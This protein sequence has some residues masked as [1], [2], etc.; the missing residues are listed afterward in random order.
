MDIYPYGFPFSVAENRK[1]L[2]TTI[3]FP[4]TFWV[5]ILK[6]E[7]LCKAFQV[8]HSSLFV[9]FLLSVSTFLLNSSFSW[10][11]CNWEWI[12]E[13]EIKLKTRKNIHWE[14]FFRIHKLFRIAS[15]ETRHAYIKQNHINY[16]T[17]TSRSTT[18]L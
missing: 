7:T 15:K 2:S 8:L 5:L 17:Q 6:S 16:I 12:G 3:K 1:G 18:S 11:A 13:K 10:D 4:T 14:S 9:F